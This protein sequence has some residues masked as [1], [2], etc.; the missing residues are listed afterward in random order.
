MPLF[1]TVTPGNARGKRAA[2]YRVGNLDKQAATRPA[3]P[4]GEMPKT[5]TVYPQ[6]LWITVWMKARRLGSC[7]FHIRP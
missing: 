6:N 2:K 1:M 3:P 4:D 7:G 5:G